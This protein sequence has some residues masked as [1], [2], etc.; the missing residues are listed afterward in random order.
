MQKIGI[1]LKIWH[2]SYKE[3]Y[4]SYKEK[5]TY[6]LFL[7]IYDIKIKIQNYVVSLIVLCFKQCKS[8]FSV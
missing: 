3:M 6:T 8:D 4:F 1:S 5:Y 7:E 2:F